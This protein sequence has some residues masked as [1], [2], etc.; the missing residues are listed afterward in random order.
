MR[1]LVVFFVQ[2]YRLDFFVIICIE[3]FYYVCVIGCIDYVIYYYWM[4]VRIKFVNFVIDRG[5]LDSGWGK[6]VFNLW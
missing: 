5:V 3:C 2:I 1:E 4:K 6:L